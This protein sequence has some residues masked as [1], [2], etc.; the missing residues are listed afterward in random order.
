MLSVSS[1]S[2]VHSVPP[3][4]IYI[5]LGFPRP[6]VAEDDVLSEVDIDHPED[7]HVQEILQHSHQFRQGEYRRMLQ[8]V[9]S[10]YPQSQGMP[11]RPPRRRALFEDIFSQAPPPP[12]SIPSLV[13]FETLQALMSDSDKETRPSG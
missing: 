13:W 9:T 4:Y 3:I 10:I 7:H 2:F 5:P 8:F 6:P 11:S 12:P 1:S